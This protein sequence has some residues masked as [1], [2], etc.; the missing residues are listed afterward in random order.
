[1]D[2]ELHE[3]LKNIPILCDVEDEDL[4]GVAKKVELKSFPKDSYIFHEGD[5][6][7]EFFIIK[8]GKIKI[9]RKNKDGK[10][11]SI[12]ILY[13]DNFFGEMAL[14]SEKPRN[15]SVK[16]LEDSE[17]FIFNKED[18]YDFLYL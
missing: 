13:P 2:S 16:C 14:L 5:K 4:I 12:A 8:S 6:G 17:L 1:M 15:A 11:E 9:L 7:V 3:I 10:E 18:F